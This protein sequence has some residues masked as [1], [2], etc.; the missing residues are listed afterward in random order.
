M[1]GVRGWLGVFLMLWLGWLAPAQAQSGGAELASFGVQRGED[2]LLLNY[3]VNFELPRGAEEALNKAV[4]LYFV[5]EAEVFR[6]RWYWRD[7]RIASAARV[8][9]IV[10][11]PLTFNYRVTFAGISQSFATRAEAFAS[12]RRGANWKV[13]EPAQLE[14]GARHYVEFSFRLDTSLLPRPMQIGIGSQPDWALSVER[15]QRFD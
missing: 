8:W 15:T 9:R 12:I 4:P 13:A 14:E 2:G 3:A 1:R 5:A 11:Q 7:K 6:D 10:F